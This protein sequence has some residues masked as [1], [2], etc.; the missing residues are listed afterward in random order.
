MTCNIHCISCYNINHEYIKTA[1]EIFSEIDLGLQK[2]HADTVSLLGGE[3][4]LHPDILRIVRYIKSKKAVCQL[5]TNGYYFFSDPEDKM[6]DQLIESGLDRL[7]LHIDRGQTV[8]KD[9]VQVIHSLL[10]KLER[11]KILVSVSWTVYR[12]GQGELPELIRAFSPYRNF[13]G[14]LSVLAKDIDKAIQPGYD[15]G[16]SPDMLD[17]YKAL[18]KELGLEPS[19]YLPSNLSDNHI[20][21]FLYVYYI[22]HNTGN[23]F[24]ISPAITRIFQSQYLRVVLRVFFR[25]RLN[26]K[27][28]YPALFLTAMLETLIK[29][30]RIN[31]FF[32]LV[33]DSGR[34]RYIK[35]LYLNLQDG[36][37]YDNESGDIAMCYHCPDATVRNGKL[38]PV[39][40]A[41]RINPLPGSHPP[42]RIPGNLYSLVYQ[43]L[44]QV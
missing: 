6:L 10:K 9:A 20:K 8:Y 34:L 4:I 43:H 38:T 35:M 1:E 22:N 21:W 15:R 41:D 11:K 13:D 7:I 5:L 23:T 25:K 24:Y 29:P 16:D 42:D 31:D 3:P 39:C 12:E 14:F 36:P 26:R 37:E 2:R 19:V 27:S 17:E 44:G 40:L 32:R 28:L 33:K 18:R 30:E